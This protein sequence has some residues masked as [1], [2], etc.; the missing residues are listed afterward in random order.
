MYKLAIATLPP[1]QEQNSK[2]FG[3]LFSK[4][5]MLLAMSLKQTSIFVTNS[6]TWPLE[7]LDHQLRDLSSLETSHPGF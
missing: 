3:C 6:S 4:V 7:T 1:H 2:R 5:A